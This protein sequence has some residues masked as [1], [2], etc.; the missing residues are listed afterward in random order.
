MRCQGVNRVCRPGFVTSDPFKITVWLLVL[1]GFWWPPANEVAGKFSNESGSENTDNTYQ[2]FQKYSQSVYKLPGSGKKF[3]HFS[4]NTQFWKSA[5]C[6]VTK[7]VIQR[8][9]TPPAGSATTSPA[10]TASLLS[11]S[12][13]CLQL[14]CN[15]LSQHC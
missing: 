8:L 6:D 1:E 15:K 14:Q 4:S 11:S 10:A 3:H 12:P 5:L 2:S 13:H 7:V 9:L